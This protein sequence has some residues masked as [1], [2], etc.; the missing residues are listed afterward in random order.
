MRN[1]HC[2]LPVRWPDGQTANLSAQCF[3][4]F[5]LFH[6]H[7]AYFLLCIYIPSPF[8]TKIK[9]LSAGNFLSLLPYLTA[10]PNLPEKVTESQFS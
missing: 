6:F 10:L 3:F 2:Q 8:L 4:P 1:D 9:F 7:L 5:T